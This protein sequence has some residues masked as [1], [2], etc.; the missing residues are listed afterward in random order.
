MGDKGS[1]AIATSLQRLLK[2]RWKRLMRH[3][4][5][6]QSS[7]AAEPV[8]N[9][10]IFTRRLQELVL[11]AATIPRCPSANATCKVLRQVRRACGDVRNADVLLGLLAARAHRGR[12]E[13]ALWAPLIEQLKGERTAAQLRMRRALDGLGVDA[14][15]RRWQKSLRRWP[16]EDPAL[17][18]PLRSR[19]ADHLKQR[20]A[21]FLEARAAVLAAGLDVSPRA[22]SGSR[23]SWTSAPGAGSGTPIPGLVEEIHALRLA[24]KRLRYALEAA[25]DL[26]DKAAAPAL[27][28]LRAIQAALGHWHDLEMLIDLIVAHVGRKKFLRRYPAE[29]LRLL[30][31]VQRFHATKDKRA[32]EALALTAAM[33][34]IEHV[35]AGLPVQDA[36]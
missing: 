18:M 2:D 22:G 5:R 6:V 36:K 29:A 35:L 15:H 7:E 4:K 11:L 34:S 32:A 31:H 16:G 28:R 19:L 30:Q 13:A 24:G 9:L 25:G 17:E 3:L 33:E 20:H 26:G 1:P 10:R 23:T 27:R 14:L 12:A 8:H 21:E